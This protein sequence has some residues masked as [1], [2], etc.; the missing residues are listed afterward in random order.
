MPFLSP[1][2]QCQNSEWKAGKNWLVKQKLKVVLLLQL[3]LVETRFHIQHEPIPH[4][5]SRQIYKVF[6]HN[7]AT[8]WH[9]MAEHDHR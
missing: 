4:T 2:E 1:N 7:L 5:S 9:T 6:A 3:V 8:D